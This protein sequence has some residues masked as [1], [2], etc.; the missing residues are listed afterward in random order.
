[1]FIDELE[2]FFILSLVFYLLNDLDLDR[3]VVLVILLESISSIDQSNLS[4]IYLV[5]IL[6]L[7]NICC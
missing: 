5:N 7:F 2:L 4:F 6:F 3:I 1:V